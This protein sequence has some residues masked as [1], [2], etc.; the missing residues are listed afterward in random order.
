MI[1]DKLKSVFKKPNHLDK[2]IE[3][4]G[5][6]VRTYNIL[7]RQGIGTVGGLVQLSWNDLSKFR[8]MHRRGIEEVEGVLEGL[9]LGLRKGDE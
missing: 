7:K 5:F 6:T 1:L 2:T 3:Q 9:G 8:R 4:L